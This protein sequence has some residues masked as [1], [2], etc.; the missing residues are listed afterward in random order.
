MG[1]FCVFKVMCLGGRRWRIGF[2]TVIVI[3][4]LMLLVCGSGIRNGAKG[5]LIG[6]CVSCTSGGRC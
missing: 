5:L 4:G 2:I 6:Y 1:Y 3:S